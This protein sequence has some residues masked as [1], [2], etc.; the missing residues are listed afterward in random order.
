[1]FCDTGRC[2]ASITAGRSVG[3]AGA[4]GKPQPD[5]HVSRELEGEAVNPERANDRK[6]TA[7]EKEGPGDR[8][9]E[10]NPCIN[11]SPAKMDARQRP[12][13]TQVLHSGSLKAKPTGTE[14]GKQ[15]STAT[16]K[17]SPKR[18]RPAPSPS[19]TEISLRQTNCC[20]RTA[21]TV[22]FSPSFHHHVLQQIPVKPAARRFIRQTKNVTHQTP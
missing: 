20:Q 9:G 2:R 17:F 5:A 12:H 11:G 15:R 7:D 21:H 8:S 22:D 10:A 19:G 18:G 1:M 3:D 6:I 4:Q 13:T 14:P 16:S